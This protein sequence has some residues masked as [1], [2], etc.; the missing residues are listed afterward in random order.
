MRLT[1]ARALAIFLFGACVGGV[2]AYG[3]A[4]HSP[5]VVKA[6]AMLAPAYQS[7]ETP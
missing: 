2:I 6:R 4:L 3:D 1:F 5:L 7:P